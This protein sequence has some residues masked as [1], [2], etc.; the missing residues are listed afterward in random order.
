[1]KTKTFDENF[2]NFT[3]VKNSKNYFFEKFIKLVL[4]LDLKI[5]FSIN[6]IIDNMF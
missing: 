1:M 5:F 3:A 4:M 6:I 2:K